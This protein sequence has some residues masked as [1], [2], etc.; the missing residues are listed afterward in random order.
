M[1]SQPRDRICGGILRATIIENNAQ[2]K[3]AAQDGGKCIS[4]LLTTIITHKLLMPQSSSP[5]P[6]LLSLSNSPHQVTADRA[7]GALG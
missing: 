1:K 3:A 7:Q 6:P 4:F 5:T 2:V